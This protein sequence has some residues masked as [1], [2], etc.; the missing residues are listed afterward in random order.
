M[1]ILQQRVFQAKTSSPDAERSV[2]CLVIIEARA[3]I[4]Y[5]LGLS[6]KLGGLSNLLFQNSI[7]YF[8]VN[9]SVI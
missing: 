9:Q 5:R 6:L 3:C 7:T 2:F 4:E 1:Q 8:L